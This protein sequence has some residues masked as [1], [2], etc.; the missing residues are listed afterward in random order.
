MSQGRKSILMIAYTNYRT[1]PRVV[2]AAEAAAS[3]GF[4]VDFLALRRVDD[5]EEELLRGVRVI[6][7]KQSRYRGGGTLR[8]MLSYLEFF[9]R[10]FFKAAAL[11]FKRGTCWCK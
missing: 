10:C 3:A 9:L 4:E 8:Y 6:H 5:P 1:D 2:R 11:Q 7:L